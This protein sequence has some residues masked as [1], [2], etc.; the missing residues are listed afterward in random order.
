MRKRL[1]FVGLFLFLFTTVVWTQA[2]RIQ[3]IGTLPATCTVGNIYLKTG[4]SP[5]FYVCLATNTWSGP[6]GAG[7]ADADYGDVT[8]SA[9]G[10]TWTID[11]DVVSYAKLQ[12]VSAASRL[13]GRGDGGS[14]DVQEITLGTGLS[15]SGT[16]LSSTGGSGVA[17]SVTVA[18]KAADETVNNSAALQSDDHLA[19]TCAANTMYRFDMM[20]LTSAPSVNS[21]FTFGWSLPASTTMNWSSEADLAGTSSAAE[22]GG[23][24]GH[25][26]TTSGSANALKTAA[27]TINYNSSSNAPRGVVFRGVV[28]VAGTG[29]TCQL[30]WSQRAATAEDSKV[31]KGSNIVTT[32][33]N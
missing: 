6:L 2:T 28:F 26:D 32:Q 3:S 21:D 13:L 23:G 25:R 7:L 5:G 4:G 22:A 30:Q 15:M 27:D 11:N 12:N 9:S 18:V 8:V 33:L 29:G 31:L 10:A 20:L 17:G 24:F 14:G 19:F 16:T 1:M